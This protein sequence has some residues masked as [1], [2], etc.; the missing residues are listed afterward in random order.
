MKK[1]QIAILISQKIFP[2]IKKIV[3]DVQDAKDPNSEGGSKI[4]HSEQQEIIF[5][6]LTNV[7]PVIADIIKEL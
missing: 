1:L 3:D 5:N 6:N 7:V 2:V 4:T